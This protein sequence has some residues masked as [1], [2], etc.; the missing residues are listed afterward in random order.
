MLPNYLYVNFYV[1]VTVCFFVGAQTN[2]SGA[3]QLC[4]CTTVD[5]EGLST[6][7]DCILAASNTEIVDAFEELVSVW[8]KDI[9]QVMN[10]C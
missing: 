9:E 8:C 7:A 10:F 3:I 4:D 6:A 2:V 5:I 1:H